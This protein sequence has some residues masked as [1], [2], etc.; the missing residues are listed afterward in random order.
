MEFEIK[1]DVEGR[2]NYQLYEKN[3]SIRQVDEAVAK[4]VLDENKY[5]VSKYFSFIKIPEI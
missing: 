3:F 2:C 5:E 1:S 4:S